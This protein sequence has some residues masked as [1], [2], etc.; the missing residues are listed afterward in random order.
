[1]AIRLE[2]QLFYLYFIFRHATA[3][4]LVTCFLRRSLSLWLSFSVAHRFLSPSLSFSVAFF[5]RS[6]PSPSL[7][8]AVTRFLSPSLPSS[9]DFSLVS[10]ASHAV[11]L[12]SSLPS[13][14]Q[15]LNLSPSISLSLSFSV[16]SFQYRFLLPS[17]ASSFRHFLSPLI[18]VLSVFDVDVLNNTGR[19]PADVVL[20]ALMRA[21]DQHEVIASETDILDGIVYR[22]VA[23]QT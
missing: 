8:F 22:L 1:M 11:S 18:S 14:P 10:A 20:R 21:Y 12:P 16:A 7:P 17:L 2:S 19:T 5:L 4:F 15:S 13:S 23:P 3:S 9:F 6:F